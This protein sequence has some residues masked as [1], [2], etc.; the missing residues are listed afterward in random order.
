V[1]ISKNENLLNQK[2]VSPKHITFFA[3]ENS[4]KLFLSPNGLKLLECVGLLS[5]TPMVQT[6]HILDFVHESYEIWNSNEKLSTNNS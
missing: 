6:T 5:K 4:S 2:I 1:I 3:L